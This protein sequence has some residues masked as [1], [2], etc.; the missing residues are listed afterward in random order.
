MA[1]AYLEENSK[2]QNK[3]EK[4]SKISEKIRDN[5]KNVLK[6]VVVGDN[7]IAASVG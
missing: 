2:K 1:W 4:N 3:R 7:G 5:S 6:I